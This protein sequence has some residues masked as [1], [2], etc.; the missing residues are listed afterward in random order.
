LLG[1]ML[2]E[3]GSPPE[4]RL[5][6]EA[7]LERSPNRFNSLYGAGRAAESSGDSDAAALYYGLLLELTKDADTERDALRHAREYSSGSDA[8]GS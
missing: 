5:A 4:A 3:L 6:Y 1:D 8:A 7:A 2:L